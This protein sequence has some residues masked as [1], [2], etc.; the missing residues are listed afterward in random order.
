MD[1]VDAVLDVVRL[2]P[3]TVRTATPSG[4][5]SIDLASRVEFHL[6]YLGHPVQMLM[7]IALND[8]IRKNWVKDW[9]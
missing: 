7:A 2:D 4:D 8:C 3:G 9:R 6:E 1:A 5:D